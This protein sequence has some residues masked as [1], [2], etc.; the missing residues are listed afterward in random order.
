[1]DAE[2][3]LVHIE[4]EDAVG[5]LHLVQLCDALKL[6]LPFGLQSGAWDGGE[7]VGV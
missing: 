6:G 2:H 3:G 4:D 1:V 5:V 7:W